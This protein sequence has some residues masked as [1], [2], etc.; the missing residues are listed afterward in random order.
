MVGLNCGKPRES[1][2]GAKEWAET[3]KMSYH[4]V[5]IDTGPSADEMLAELV[6][7]ARQLRSKDNTTFQMT[8]DFPDERP[9]RKSRKCI[10][11]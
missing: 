7:A 2:E 10:V 9:R 8:G 3:R 1:T 4:E 6:R 5:T 11:M